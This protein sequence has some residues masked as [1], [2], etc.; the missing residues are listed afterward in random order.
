MPSSTTPGLQTQTLRLSFGNDL[1]DYAGSMASRVNSAMA[2]LHQIQ[3]SVSCAKKKA[4]FADLH[5]I[6]ISVSCAKKKADF[7]DLHQIQISVSCAKNKADFA[8]EAFSEARY[9]EPNDG[10]FETKSKAVSL[11]RGDDSR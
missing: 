8:G 3:I 9:S 2:N 4:D 5:Q 7:A 1:G 6:Q 11:T 10:I